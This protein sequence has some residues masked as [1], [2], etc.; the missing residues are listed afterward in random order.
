MRMLFAATL[1]LLTGTAC[2]DTPIHMPDGRACLKNDR[3]EVHSC[4]TTNFAVDL[5]DGAV[6]APAR[7]GYVGPDGR[8]YAPAGDRSVVDVRTGETPQVS[9]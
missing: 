7:R 1:A 3:G 9:K 5:R 4:T 8:Y 2:A 6:Y